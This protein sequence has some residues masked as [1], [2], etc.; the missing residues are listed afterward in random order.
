MECLE[1][2]WDDKRLVYFCDDCL[3][4]VFCVGRGG[5]RVVVVVV[6]IF[7]FFER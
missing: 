3:V 5:E 4:N 7:D 1:L 2:K 6:G